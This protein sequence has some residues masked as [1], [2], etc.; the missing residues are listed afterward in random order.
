[1]LT[2]AKN[3]FN[4][5][6]QILNLKQYDPED[7]PNEPISIFIVPTYT[8]GTPNEE[9]QG[10]YNWLEDVANDFRVTKVFLEN[11]KYAVFGLGDN[12]YGENY[13][14]IAKK[15]DTLLHKLSATR[16]LAVGDGDGQYS[17]QQFEFWMIKLWPSLLAHLGKKELLATYKKDKYLKTKEIEKGKEKQKE[18]EKEQEEIK[19]EEEQEEEESSDEEGEGGEPL[20]DLEDLGKMLKKDKEPEEDLN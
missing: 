20:V 13:C 5:Q 15:I 3:L 12:S 6:G 2:E 11:I 17:E 1:L 16:I 18:V 9:T 14:V 7:L 8:D 19:K 4:I 10:F